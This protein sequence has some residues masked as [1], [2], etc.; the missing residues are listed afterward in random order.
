MRTISRRRQVITIP[1]GGEEVLNV[2]LYGDF[3]SI[4]I[5]SDLP[6]NL[7]I[8]TYNDIPIAQFSNITSRVYEPLPH[9]VISLA[10]QFKIVI[11]NPKT[12]DANVKVII[13]QGV[14][15]Q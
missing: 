2:N 6:V 1:A 9:Q 8:F 10:P 3:V 4:N 12:E 11:R 7:Y 13:Q 14:L 5:T 15:G